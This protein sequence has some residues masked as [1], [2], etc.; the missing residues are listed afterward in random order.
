M[1][2]GGD[3]LD[4]SNSDAQNSPLYCVHSPS[5]EARQ[6]QMLFRHALQRK[7]TGSDRT[8]HELERSGVALT[9]ASA[10]RPSVDH[11]NPTQDVRIPIPVSGGKT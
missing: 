7:V 2:N 3:F 10:G 1:S 9:K 6:K 8:V 4:S 11:P 5:Q